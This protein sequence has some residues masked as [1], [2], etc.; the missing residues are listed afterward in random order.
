GSGL[1]DALKRLATLGRIDKEAVDATVKD[2]QRALLGSDVNVRLV[3]DLSQKIRKRSLEEKPPP[4]MTPREHVL[5]IIYQELSAVVGKAAPVELKKQTLLLAG[6]YGAGKTTTCAKMARWY[7]RKGLRPAVIC[8]DVYRPA[9]MEQLEQLCAKMGVPFYGEKGEKD[10]VRIVRSGLKAHSDVDVRIVDTAG[11][12]ALD[13]DLIRELKAIV[14]AAEPDGKILVL[15]AAMGQSARDH[16]RAFHEAVGLT[17]VVITKMDGTAK[18]GGA[19]SAV[20]ETGAGVAFVGTGEDVDEFERFEPD[21]FLSRLL[22]MGDLRALAEKAEEALRGDEVD[23]QGMLKGKFTLNDLYSQLEALRKLG[24][25]KNVLGMLPLG[26]AGVNLDEKQF[27]M[28]KG[29][30]EKYKYIMDSMTPEEKENPKLL[31]GSRITRVARGS[32]ST[33]E[34]VRELLKYHRTMQN[35]LKRLG[36]SRGGMKKLMKMFGS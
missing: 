1:R 4:G 11:R 15:D 2:I 33:P 5:R 31:A 7:Q 28:T 12:H 25:L 13:G 35:T 14:R 17:G 26:A 23:V 30:L 34:E 27:E 8:A 24:P 29:K 22:G 36:S 18:G 21:G 32:G 6:L 9:A 20:A 10:P 19:L 3:M 16:A